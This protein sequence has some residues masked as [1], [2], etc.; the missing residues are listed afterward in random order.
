MVP[1]DLN[2][3]VTKVWN[4]V[5]NF[6]NGSLSFQVNIEADGLLHLPNGERQKLGTAEFYNGTLILRLNITNNTV[7]G[8]ILS[9]DFESGFS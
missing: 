9:L 8:E 1:V 4:F 5:S 7:M 6:T 3:R 2:V